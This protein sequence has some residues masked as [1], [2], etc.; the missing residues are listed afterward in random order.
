MAMIDPDTLISLADRLRPILP[1]NYR[2]LGQGDLNVVGTC[3][4][5]AGG[6]A[7]VWIGE[8]SDQKVAVKSY[9]CYSSADYILIYTA[10]HPYPSCVMVW[11]SS[12]TN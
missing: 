11:C 8:L 9:R 12:L 7:N 2:W 10:S 1:S 6:F 5:D 4:L 3:P